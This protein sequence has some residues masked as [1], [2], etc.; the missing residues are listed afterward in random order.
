MEKEKQFK[1]LCNLATDLVG[2]PEGSLSVKSRKQM[3]QIPRAIVSVIARLEDKTHHDIISKLLGRHRT[4]IYHYEK[5]HKANFRSFPK[6]RE[7]Y[8][9]ILN[10]Y[11]D[12][13]GEQKQFLSQSSYEQY[14][15]ENSIYSSE[16]YQ[17]KVNLKVQKFSID[18]K[19]SHK[20]FYNQMELIKLALKDYNYELKVR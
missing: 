16:T 20:D 1:N 14:L 13:K 19:F 3:Y 5:S 7:L 15:Q 6:Y 11:V 12:T 4:L 18:L 9:K 10:A 17:V 8:S 2:L